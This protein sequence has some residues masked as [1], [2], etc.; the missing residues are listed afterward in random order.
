M[1]CRYP[2]AN[3]SKP[4][5]MSHSIEEKTQKIPLTVK[6]EKKQYKRKSIM[7]RQDVEMSGLSSDRKML[8]QEN[9]NIQINSRNRR[10]TLK[11]MNYEK[12]FLK[13]MTKID[14]NDCVI[15]ISGKAFENLLQR[16]KEEEELEQQILKDKKGNKNREERPRI[17]RDLVRLVDEKGK[18]FFR[19]SP[20]HKVDLVNFFKENKTAIVAMCGDGANDCGALLSSDVG[21]SLCHKE[22]N[23]VTSH[24]YS[25]EE[26]ISCI[27]LILKNG[28]ACFENSVILFKYMVVYS[29]TQ[30]TT[31]LLLYTVDRDFTP[32]QW[33]YQDFV[34]SLVTCL[35]TT[36]TGPGYKLINDKPPTTILNMKFFLVVFGQAIIQITNV[37]LFFLYF[38]KARIN[39]EEDEKE[40]GLQV[41]NS[42]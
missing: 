3:E 12:E 19:M 31:V 6:E 1:Y 37:V 25:S 41:F 36:K 18:I 40:D 24:F 9:S 29:V 39:L 14:S 22:G 4:L 28:R 23:N 38:S 17:Y 42:V 30:L 7:L 13:M 8:N 33:L 27:E 16:F 35:I 20:G 10:N 2:L 5:D 21:I 11:N 32:I 26:S 15:C 34:I